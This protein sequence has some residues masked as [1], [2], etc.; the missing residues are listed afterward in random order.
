MS[1]VTVTV[2]LTGITQTSMTIENKIGNDTPHK[3]FSQ[4]ETCCLHPTRNLHM[5]IM[6]Q[7]HVYT[8]VTYINW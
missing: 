4:S 8:S 2:I 3:A 5:C 6:S 7:K 1:P